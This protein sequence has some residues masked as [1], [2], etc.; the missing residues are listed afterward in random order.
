[1]LKFA[2]GVRKHFQERFWNPTTGRF[3]TI[4]LDGNLHDYGY[5]FL[6][7]EAVVFGLPSPAQAGSI[8]DWIGGRRTV[9]GD[10]STGDDIY[11]WRFGPRTTTLRNVDYY[12]WGWSDPQSIPWGYQVQDGG[13]VLG[14][15]Y[16]DLMAQLKTSG[17]DV[18]AGRLR[19][20]AKWFDDTQREGGYR[21]YYSKDSSRGS[22]QGGNSAGGL[23][24]DKEF[25]ESVLAPQVMLYGFLGFHPT[26]DGFQIS[27]HL[28]KDWPEV[29]VTQIHLHDRVIDV[30]ADREAGVKIR[31]VGP[32]DEEVVVH[33]PPGLRVSSAPGLNLRFDAI[34]Q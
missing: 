17:P 14:W 6:N 29:T 19:E 20:I 25:I 9:A 32:G 23:G 2:E 7:N 33:G 12:Y 16:Y 22:L 28:P 21:A 3:G 27:P 31:A 13:A 10:T 15:T 11:H 5:T 34:G 4:D 26:Y 30:T 18:A 1:L 8:C 24:L